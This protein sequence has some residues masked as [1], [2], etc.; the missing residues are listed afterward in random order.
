M[1][2]RA[3]L[4]KHA[5]VRCVV[6]LDPGEDLG[7]RELSVIDRCSGSGDSAHQAEA[8][9]RSMGRREWGRPG[10]V[11]QSSVEVV[12]GP[13]GVEVAA[14]KYS[15]HQSGAEIRCGPIKLV[16]IGVL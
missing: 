6:P 9:P 14:W 10:S 5:M 1:R 13:V 2:A 4:F 8:S 12:R 11:D 7:D 3:G 16:D 15:A